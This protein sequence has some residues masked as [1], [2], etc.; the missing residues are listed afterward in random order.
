MLN[1]QQKIRSIVSDYSLIA[2]STDLDD[3]FWHPPDRGSPN[4]YRLVYKSEPIFDVWL[5][6]DT[7]REKFGGLRVK[8]KV[9][10]FDVVHHYLDSETLVYAETFDGYQPIEQAFLLNSHHYQQQ[11]REIAEEYFE[12]AEFQAAN[13]YEAIAITE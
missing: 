9:K 7:H 3:M 12:M 2:P 6:A 5:E 10:L 8:I 11:A 1:R 13:E 4:Y